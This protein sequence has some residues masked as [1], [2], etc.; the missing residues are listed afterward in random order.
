M[1]SLAVF[2]FA[3]LSEASDHPRMRG[4]FE[5]DPQN[6]RAA[7]HADGFIARSG[8]DGEPGP[9]SW[10]E[11]VYPRFFAGN[12]EGWT[13]ATLS[14]WQDLES[15]AAFVYRGIHAQAIAQRGK[16]FVEPQYPTHA[17]W[18]VPDGHTPLWFEAKFRHEHLH[19]HGPSKYVFK[20]LRAF[21]LEGGRIHL[22]RHLVA[23]KARINLQESGPG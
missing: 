20:L 8:Y 18:W 6:L 17:L 21:D 22:D 3:I 19:D 9:P 10:G 14:L 11:M 23:E 4:F 15:L 5:S 13:P 12:R 1:P 16:W 2:T 7:E